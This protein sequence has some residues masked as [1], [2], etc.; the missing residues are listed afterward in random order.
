MLQSQK[1]LLI[2]NLK[3][4]E[5][6]PQ[7]FVFFFFATSKTNNFLAHHI[8]TDCYVMH[9]LCWD[10]QSDGTSASIPQ[11]MGSKPTRAY[12]SMFWG[13][14]RWGGGRGM[15]STEYKSVFKHSRK[16]GK[17]RIMLFCPVILDVI[18]K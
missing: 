12:A 5:S 1:A 6:L 18:Y 3:A 11:A 7:L 9:A 14:E 2:I 13:W 17:S 16:M 15:V 10:T 8:L 4:H